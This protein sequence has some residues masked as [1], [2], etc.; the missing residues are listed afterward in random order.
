MKKLILALLV[1]LAILILSFATY[2]S[3]VK[4]S[5]EILCLATNVYHEARGESFKGKL[6]VAV[7]T[8]NRTR[9]PDYPDTICGVVYQRDQ[10][11]WTRFK[12]KKIT[13]MNAWS[14]AI[15]VA[16]LAIEDPYIL[17]NFVATH[18]HNTSVNPRWG[19]AKVAKIGKHIFFV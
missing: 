19:L 18:Y 7:V 10:F 15:A 2:S 3:T 16:N 1:G 5:Q 14:D 13:D 12:N 11:S 17:G 8:I 9:S 6:A 4:Q